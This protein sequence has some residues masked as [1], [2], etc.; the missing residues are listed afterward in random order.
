MIATASI[1]LYDNKFEDVSNLINSILLSENIQF[2][3][4]IDNSKLKSLNYIGLNQKIVYIHEPSNLGFGKAHNLAINK[5]LNLNFKYHFVINPDII[6]GKDVLIEMLKF[7]SS[8]SDIGMIMPK[9]LNFDGT[10]QYLPKLL[11]SPFSIIYRK[12]TYFNQFYLKFISNYELRFVPEDFIYQ[13]PLL[14]GCFTLLNLEKIRVIGLFDD[15]FFMYFEDW[16]L[17]RRMCLKFKTIYFPS[18]HV[19]H[20]YDSGANKKIK[21]LL[22]FFNS[23]FKYFFK[24]GWIFDFER[25]K[26]NKSVLRQFK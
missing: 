21:L 3:F 26:I 4:L 11:P 9:I 24:W 6:L 20:G 15:R 25:I 23:Y 8:D 18:V 17:S 12:L 13:T 7:V 19:Y 1:V 5:S 2:L 14:S 10:I 16:D 22:I